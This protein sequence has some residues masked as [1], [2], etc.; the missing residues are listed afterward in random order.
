[1]SMKLRTLALAVMGCMLAPAFAQT[2]QVVPAQ[3]APAAPGS[4][5]IIPGP[6]VVVPGATVVSSAPRQSGTMC[7]L[8]T[9]GQFVPSADVAN[10]QC[11]VQV[12]ARGET[13]LAGQL[14]EG[15]YNITLSGGGGGGGGGSA[16]GAAGRTGFDGV[17]MRT[18]QYLAPGMY[19]L[20]VG[21]GGLGGRGCNAVTYGQDG[22]PT[23]VSNAYT[24]QT[25]AGFPQAEYWARG[26]SYSRTVVAGSGGSAIAGAGVPA[27]TR[28]V[29]PE[30]ARTTTVDG[31]RVARGG[32]GGHGGPDC[33]AG[34]AGENGYIQITPAS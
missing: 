4:A 25:I 33:N 30:P 18:T 34:Q 8:N 1:M 9:L 15:N 32:A 2:I 23:S 3:V 27:T 26:M 11:F 20:T 19:R 5:V 28:V 10:R 13:P 29:A 24:G 6:A 31:L 7:D 14:A 12:V 22:A 21:A 17:P 16:T